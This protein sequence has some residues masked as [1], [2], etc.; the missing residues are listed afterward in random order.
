MPF[1]LADTA[2]NAACDGIV[3]LVDAGAGAGIIRIYQGTQ[4]ANPQTAHGSILLATL[5]FTDPA[6]GNA[7][8][9]VATA[10]A[11]TSDTS[12]DATGTAQWARVLDSDGI[13][14]TDAVMD[15]DIGQAS[16]TLDFDDTSF[17]AGGTA[18]ISS[19]TVTVPMA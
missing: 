5:T 19:M 2:R 7:A 15:M 12:V 3:D 1:R 8:A 6:F 17:I 14:P 18:A 10:S 13:D 9:G 4:P 11:I 16:G